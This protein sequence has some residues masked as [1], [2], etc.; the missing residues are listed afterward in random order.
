[1]STEL[2]IKYL[3][4]YKKLGAT[5]I[6]RGQWFLRKAFNVKVLKRTTKIDIINLLVGKGFFLNKMRF[7]DF[8]YDV[9]SL[10]VMKEII[11]YSWVD[12]KEYVAETFDCDDFAL[13]FRGHVSETYGINSIALAKHIKVVTDT[14]KEMW[15]RAVVFLAVDNGIMNAYLLETQNDKLIKLNKNEE[16]RL[17]KWTYKLSEIEF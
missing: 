11:K 5:L 3:K 13:A 10:D 6:E 4:A 16:I 12:K 15:H 8:W 9:I 7:T 17:G 14:G 1:M 2:E